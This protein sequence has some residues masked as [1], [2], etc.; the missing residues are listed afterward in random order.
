M[1]F[2]GFGVLPTFFGIKVTVNYTA[3]DQGT[4]QIYE[5]IA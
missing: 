2:A 4:Q 1:T 3:A 5:V